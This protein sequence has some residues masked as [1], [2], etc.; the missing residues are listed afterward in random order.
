MGFLDGQTTNPTYFAKSPEVQSRL[1]LG[2]KFSRE[3]IYEFYREI[4]QKV[5]NLIPHGSVSIEVYADSRTKAEDM[6]AQGR[7][8]FGWIPNAHIKLPTTTEGLKAAEMA[9]KERMRINM[10][11]VFSQEQAAAVY[12]ATRGAKRGDVFVSPFVGRQ[13]DQGINGLDLI[14]NIIKMYSQGDGHVM[15]LSASMRSLDQF[16]TCIHYGTDIITAAKKFLD[17]WQATG[18][19]WPDDN[20]QPVVSDEHQAIPYSEISLDKPWSQYNIQHD[21]TD[22][23]LE[24]F[25]ADWNA[26]LK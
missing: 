6:L 13:W 23:S 7:E 12:A 9:V 5:S 8:M 19:Y 25:V 16:L 11:V 26:L 22:I 21:F 1:A 18:V 15:V 20:F 14:K 10:T 2:G 17:E 4:V 24:K 3:E